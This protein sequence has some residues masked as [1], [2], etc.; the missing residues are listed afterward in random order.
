MIYS[1]FYSWAEKEIEKQ[2]HPTIRINP[3]SID[4][5]GE[6]GLIEIEHTIYI[7]MRRGHFGL[8]GEEKMDSAGVE[9]EAAD[10][11]SST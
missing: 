9:D 6:N 11:Q 8:T 7:R 5:E 2:L 4:W 3:L 10:G 1:P